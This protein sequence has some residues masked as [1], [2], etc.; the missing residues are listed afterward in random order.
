MLEGWCPCTLGQLSP[1]SF[2][3]KGGQCQLLQLMNIPG[4]CGHLNT[5][6]NNNGLNKN[7]SGGCSELVAIRSEGFRFVWMLKERGF[8][9]EYFGIQGPVLGSPV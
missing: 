9:S 8:E 6:I 1:G 4:S 2:E 7:D 3:D 5:T